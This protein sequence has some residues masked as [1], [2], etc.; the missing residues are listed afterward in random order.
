MERANRS[1][2]CECGVVGVGGVGTE[3]AGHGVHQVV[4]RADGEQAGVGVHGQ[5]TPVFAVGADAARG[6]G[7]VAATAPI[8][9]LVAL[10]LV[11][12]LDRIDQNT[13]LQD[14]FH[15][16]HFDPLKCLQ[17]N[18]FRMI[19]CW[20][21]DVR[22]RAPIVLPICLDLPDGKQRA[23]DPL[24]GHDRPPRKFPGA[25]PAWLQAENSALA[26]VSSRKSACF[27][28]QNRAP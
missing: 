24:E 6:V 14:C 19:G 27:T 3:F 12:P 11:G 1:S 5:F 10:F 25:Y 13:A 2:G 15:N 17:H 23:A 8:R 20:T 7:V 16:R 26:V 9:E 18:S 21:V 28:A 22:P 4:A